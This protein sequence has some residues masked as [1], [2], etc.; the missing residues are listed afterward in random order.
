MRILV[1]D[2]EAVT[3]KILTHWLERWNFEVLTAI[4]GESAWEVLSEGEPTIAILDW[5]MPKIAGPAL[6]RRIREHASGRVYVVLLT[7]RGSR[8]DLIAGLDAG[9]DDYIVKP[10]DP[11]ELRARVNVGVRV[12]TLQQ[13]LAQQVTE[14]QDALSKVRQLSGMLPICS[15]CKR[16]RSD[17]DYWE[18]IETYI[19]EH[20]NTQFSHGI[21]PSCMERSMNDF[22]VPAEDRPKLKPGG[23]R[24]WL[25][26]R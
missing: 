11:E 20:S 21:C 8:D 17:Q 26:G 25:K 12:L 15:Y 22:E 10:F 14:L 19:G 23:W 2:D 16:I 4:D 13:R 6:C 18:S 5:M 3:R 24:T 9:A 7:A 1:A